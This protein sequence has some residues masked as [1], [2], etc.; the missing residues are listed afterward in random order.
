MVGDDHCDRFQPS[1][2]ARRFVGGPVPSR[3]ITRW[4]GPIHEPSPR[5]QLTMAA[6]AVIGYDGTDE[7]AR[8][9]EFAA[10]AL[11]LD[12]AIVANIWHDAAT[13]LMVAPLA[14]PPPV[15]SAA[16]E[17]ALLR[18]AEV[19]AQEGVDRALA[20]EL[21]AVSATRWGSSVGDIARALG[22]LAEESCSELI[23]VGRRHASALESALLGSVSAA[24]VRDEHCPVLVVPS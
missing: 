3:H 9:L 18:A 1:S 22:D 7:A 20:A 13:D 10:H 8:A 23:V 17:S 19:V 24:A 6:R 2:S 4:A 5:Q 16:R 21:A 12:S 14:G 11:T 15:P